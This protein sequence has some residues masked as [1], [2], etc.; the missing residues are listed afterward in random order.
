MSFIELEKIDHFR[1]SLAEHKQNLAVLD[2]QAEDARRPA[3]CKIE[4]PFEFDDGVFDEHPEGTCGDSTCACHS[5]C[6]ARDCEAC[7]DAAIDRAERM[8]EGEDR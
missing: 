8:A 5:D 4:A 1:Q 7:F 2:E 6:D 3:N